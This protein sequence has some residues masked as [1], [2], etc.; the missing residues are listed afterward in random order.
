MWVYICVCLC[1][2]TKHERAVCCNVVDW[3]RV[4]VLVGPG[5][6]LESW[7]RGCNKI[8][9]RICDPISGAGLDDVYGRSPMYKPDA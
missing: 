8:G 6:E 1:S 7:L 5:S 3:Q 4:F 9:K 2:D